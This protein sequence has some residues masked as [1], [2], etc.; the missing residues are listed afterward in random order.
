MKEV[1]AELLADPLPP[2][3]SGNITTSK[4]TVKL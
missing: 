2:T 3:A 1:E 4:P